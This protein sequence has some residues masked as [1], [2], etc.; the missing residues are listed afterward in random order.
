[1]TRYR[2]QQMLAQYGGY[3][4]EMTPQKRRGKD[5]YSSDVEGYSQR[6]QNTAYRLQQPPLQSQSKSNSLPYNL[7]SGPQNRGPQI[8]S[9][10]RTP[11]FENVNRIMFQN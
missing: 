4:F 10:S 2:R 3:N 11:N 7:N 6:T 5:G 8:D 9:A 1:M